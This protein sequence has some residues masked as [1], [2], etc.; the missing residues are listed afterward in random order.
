L[1]KYKRRNI[2]RDLYFYQRL[3]ILFLATLTTQREERMEKGEG[4][5]L[6]VCPLNW[7]WRRN[8]T[9][10]KITYR[11]PALSTLTN[12]QNFPQAYLSIVILWISYDLLE[13]GA[14]EKES[15]HD[16]V[17]YGVAVTDR[18]TFRRNLC[19]LLSPCLKTEGFAC[20]LY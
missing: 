15:L 8:P 17:H 13:D 7:H 6:A 9:D 20:L 4:S 16:N 11:G 12:Q 10:A 5:R 2:R 18:V 19:A 1:E 3:V 14:K